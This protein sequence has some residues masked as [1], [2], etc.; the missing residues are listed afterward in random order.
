M[1][2]DISTLDTTMSITRN[3]RNST[4]PIWNAVFSSESTKAGIEHVGGQVGGRAR[5]R[6]SSPSW[7]ISARSVSRV[8]RSMNSRSGIERASE[9]PRPA[10]SSWPCTAG[11][12][13]RWISCPTG[14]MT[15]NVRNSDRPM[16][17][18][19]GGSCW[20]PIAWRSSDST[21]TMRVNEVSMIRIAGASV[22]TV[23][24]ERICTAVDDFLRRARLRRLQRQL[25]EG[26]RLAS[27]AA[28]ASSARPAAAATAR[29]RLPTRVSRNDREMRKAAQPITRALHG[30][31]ERVRG[32]A[33]L[34]HGG[35]RRTRAS[36]RR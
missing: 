36:G 13:S 4:K 5:L 1:P 24:S 12:R 27:A 34:A 29:E 6:R 2:I 35:R 21:M 19:F 31:A 15:K 32:R 23:S 22:R 3:G 17:T 16:S 33:R 10:R 26:D 30:L 18:W 28:T 11:R 8:C 14:A 25:R 20:T 9:A 7:T